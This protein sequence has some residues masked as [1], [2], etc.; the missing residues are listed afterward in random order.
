ML[1]DL[2]EVKFG[3]Y[4]HKLI[5]NGWGY[6]VAN[7]TNTFMFFYNSGRNKVKG[8]LSYP[9]NISGKLPVIIWNRGGNDKSG[10]LDDF[11]AVGMLGEIAS[12]GYVVFSSQYRENDEF[13]GDD[14][15]DVLNLINEAKLFEFSDGNNIGMEGWSRGGMMSY[16]ALS[17]TNDVNTCIIIAGLA[18]LI[19]NEKYNKKL[20]IVYKKHF[21]TDDVNEF[22]KKKKERSAVYWP[23]K[24]SVNTSILFIHGTDDDKISA[25]DSKIMY[26]KL[27]ELNKNTKYDLKLITGGDHYLKNKK[28]EVALLRRSWFKSNLQFN[29]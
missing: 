28:K 8:Y 11:L 5:E 18:D 1:K 13:G 4:E 27:T 10:L 22:E 25:E 29:S 20:G 19:S 23:D 7:N 26:E 17:K 21:G 3:I 2:K 12:W 14:L 16:L 15:Y 6:D 9:K 24:I